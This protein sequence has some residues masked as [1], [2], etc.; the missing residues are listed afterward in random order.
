MLEKITNWMI[1][2]PKRVIALGDLFTT[3]S[4]WLGMAGLAGKVITTAV[5]ALNN[6][7]N[8]SSHVQTL[9]ETLPALPTGWIPE[10][11]GGIVITV[12]LLLLGLW[13][14]HVGKHLDR[15]LGC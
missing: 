13:L 5:G 10:S 15:I 2:D 4:Y 6:L 14:R 7:A 8:K 11:V 9:A 1:T 3:L 12:S